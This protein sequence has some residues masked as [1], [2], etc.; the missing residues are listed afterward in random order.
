[1]SLNVAVSSYDNIFAYVNETANA[2]SITN[3]RIVAYYNIVPHNHTIAK[4]NAFSNYYSLPHIRLRH[5]FHF[6]FS[7]VERMKF[8]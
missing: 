8:K 6:A 7:L 4:E 3:L 1:M 2:S 5:F